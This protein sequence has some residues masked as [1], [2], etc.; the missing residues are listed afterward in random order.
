MNIKSLNKKKLPIV[1]ID[2]SLEKFKDKVL[3]KDKLD[4]ANEILKTVGLPK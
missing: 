3:F 4:N 1:K 2:E